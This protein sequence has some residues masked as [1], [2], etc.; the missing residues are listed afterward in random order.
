MPSLA[1]PGKL[2][3]QRPRNGRRIEPIEGV[4]DGCDPGDMSPL[5]CHLIENH[6]CTWYTSFFL[7]FACN[8]QES[9]EKKGV[10]IWALT[11]C[12]YMHA[13]HVY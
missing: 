6:A 10:Y 7:P 8:F 9:T 12:T 4:T 2:A 3:C 5:L 11:M 13:R 1:D